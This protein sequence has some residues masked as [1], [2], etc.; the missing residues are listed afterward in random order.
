MRGWL[1]LAVLAILM[2][3][4]AAGL[5][6][7]APPLNAS[8]KQGQ[9]LFNQSCMVCHTKPQITSGMY[10]PVLS[11]ETGGGDA[12]VL[13]TVISDGTPRMP[14]F[15]YHFTA[16]QIDAIVAYLKTLPKPVAA[17]SGS[18]KGGMD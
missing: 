17:A 1:R 13:R 16:A 2:A 10:G 8:Q 15:K 7:Q 14:G 4:P 9:R 11:K 18:D 5:A 6:Q 12:Q 3:T